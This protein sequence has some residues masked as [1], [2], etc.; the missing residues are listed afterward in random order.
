M[1]RKKY[2]ALFA[3]AIITFTLPLQSQEE[4]PLRDGA[5]QALTQHYIQAVKRAVSRKLRPPADVANGSKCTVAV[6]LV[7]PNEVIKVQ[8]EYCTGGGRELE[9]AV[10]KAIW[11]A[12]FPSPQHKAIFDQKL[13]I[14]ITF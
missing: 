1:L 8:I 5:K 7:Y 10:E 12:E 2:F 11:S 9:L 4:K 14:E 6:G 13:I 3:V